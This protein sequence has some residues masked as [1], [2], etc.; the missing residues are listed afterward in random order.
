MSQDVM[1]HMV[2]SSPLNVAK[3][4]WLLQTTTC[5]HDNKSWK[6]CPKSKD[7]SFHTYLIL[8]ALN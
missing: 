6:V 3:Y 2:E 1:M 5:S 8:K 4:L 7:N